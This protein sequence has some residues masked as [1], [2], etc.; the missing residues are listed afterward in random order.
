[1]Q[2]RAVETSRPD[3]A[4]SKSA[5]KRR[6]WSP[7]K[8]AELYSIDNWSNGYFAINDAGH[9]V[10]R[11]TTEPAPQIDLKV[12]VEELR[13]RD[14]NPPLLIRFSD[15]LKHRLCAIADAFD[16]AIRENAYQS[17]YR[18]VYPIKVNQQRHVVEE[19]QSLGAAH[20]F[21]LEAGSK[22]E[23]LA[24][25]AMVGDDDTPIIC[26]GFK[27]AQFI[28]AVILATKI[29]KHVI[30]VVEKFSE[31]GL[32]IEYAR[33]HDVR[34]RIG[35]RVK[36]DARGAGRWEDS[37][38]ERSKFGLF[39]SEVVEAVETLRAQDM[40]DC[41]KLLHMHLGSQ[42]NNIGNIKSA[43]NEQVRIYTELRQMGAGLEYLD[44][45]GGL[46]VDYDGTQTTAGTSV[47]YSLQEYAN[48]VVYHVKAGCDAA[49]VPHPTLI[50][51]SGRAMVAY[52]SV[53]VFNVLG[54]SSFD[55]FEPPAPMNDAQFN[56]L[57]RPVQ[58]LVEAHHELNED[59]FA[60]AYHDAD[61][62]RE[63]TIHL[64][65]LGYC[66][67][68]HRALAQRLYFTICARVL[69]FIRDLPQVPEEFQGLESLLSD[70]YFCNFSIFQSMPDSW[71]IEHM[72]PVMP[73]HRL[74]EEPT[75]RGVL[76]DITCDSDGRI[77][78]FISPRGR[79]PV[80]PLHPYR[81]GDYFLAAFLVGAYQEILGDLH[82]L[83]GDTNAVHV[84][85]DDHGEPSIDEVIE[86][87][88]IGEVL[89]YV[90]F[91]PDEL[92][93]AFRKQVEQAVRDRKLDVDEARLLRRFYE[94]GLNG[95]TY[96]T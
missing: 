91:K 86:G 96:L 89:Q 3:E 58:T 62:A 35:V 46:G 1:M 45:G 71:A 79:Q 38:G 56:D 16:T 70:T 37:G 80:L 23:L 92:R 17:N 52:H 49:D 8:S 22:P 50:S 75:G 29:G 11:P 48:D 36:L 21:G 57:P 77:D 74:N 83:F 10:V 30:P 6:A 63:E 64:F 7:E 32:I 28:E 82:N 20:G 43:L 87:D 39:V 27:D 41:L 55:R 94:G 33:K 44:V 84:S 88:T 13:R 53:L 81:G 26:N 93:R 9:V 24:I 60:E 78:H 47:N 14:L 73:I 34:P 59:N 85:I 5:R 51:E 42:I 19:I 12:L 4:A 90:Q 76:V 69:Q 72:F 40:L 2:R 67:L 61:L 65:N 31:L 95:Y 54:T 68:E 25:M 18:C 15:I 66:S